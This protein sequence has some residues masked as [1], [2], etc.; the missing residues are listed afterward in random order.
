MTDT[1]ADHIPLDGFARSGRPILLSNP[2]TGDLG[3]GFWAGTMWAEFHDRTDPGALQQLS[4]EPT[5]Y[6]P[7]AQG[8][9]PA[10]APGETV[11]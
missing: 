6:L 1:F 8:D 11:H 2:Q 7:P 10:P 4:F 5:H 3:L 9:A